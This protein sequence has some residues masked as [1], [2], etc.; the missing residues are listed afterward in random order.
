MQNEKTLIDL[1]FQK[2][3]ETW[4]FKGKHQVFLA[5]V[6]DVHPVYVTLYMQSDKIDLRKLSNNYG[7]PYINPVKDCCSNGSVERALN[8]YDIPNERLT[9]VLGGIII[10]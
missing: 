5:K 10:K 3:G 1:G 6:I 4:I 8:R 9:V 2:N 7:K